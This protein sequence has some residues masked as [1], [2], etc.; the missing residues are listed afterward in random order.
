MSTREEIKKDVRELMPAL[1]ISE[2]DS[3]LM[4]RLISLAPA[5]KQPMIAALMRDGLKMQKWEKDKKMYY[6]IAGVVVLLLLGGAF[7]AGKKM[8]EGGAV[9]EA[10]MT[11]VRSA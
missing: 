2:A 7:F 11:T 3:T 1:G 8:A 4:E 10:I 5:D 9:P 6:G